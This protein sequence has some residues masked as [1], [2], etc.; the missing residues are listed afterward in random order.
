LKAFGYYDD[1]NSYQVRVRNLSYHSQGAVE[2]WA[3][4]KDCYADNSCSGINGDSEWNSQPQPE[5][6]PQPQPQPEPTPDPEPQPEPTPE[7]EPEPE[8]TTTNGGSSSS[9]NDDEEEEEEPEDEE[10]ETDEDETDE[11]ETCKHCKKTETEKE[12]K[13]EETT[14]RLRTTANLNVRTTPGGD[15]IK[16]VSLGLGGTKLTDTPITKNGHQWIKVR[17]DDGTEGYVAQ[18]YTREEVQ[19]TLSATDRAAILSQIEELLKMIVVLQNM[20]D[21]LKGSY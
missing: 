13:V 7:P 16:M 4:Y 2:A 15:L 1:V 12:T 3:A 10:Q 5:P 19:S 8:E 21:K 6:Q 14:T 11:G 20:L 17:F 9:S 18:S